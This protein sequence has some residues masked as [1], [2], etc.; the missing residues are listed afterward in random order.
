MMFRFSYIQIV[1]VASVVFF[2]PGSY[3]L[4]HIENL[5]KKNILLLTM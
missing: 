3:N 1:T 5:K 2:G 4:G